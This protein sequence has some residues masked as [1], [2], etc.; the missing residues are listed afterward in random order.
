MIER[1]EFNDVETYPEVSNF[2]SLKCERRYSRRHDMY[3][4]I[5]TKVATRS[6]PSYTIDERA[7]SDC[8]NYSFTF[9]ECLPIDSMI[10]SHLLQVLPVLLSTL[11]AATAFQSRTTLSKRMLPSKQTVLFSGLGGASEESNSGGL[12]SMKSLQSQLASAFTALDERDQYDAVLTGLCAK[13]LDT[14]KAAS[15]DPTAQALR[16]PMQLVEEM[17]TRRIKASPRSLMAF[18]DVS[19]HF[20]GTFCMIC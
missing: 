1:V 18:I 16:D 8:I 13:I 4:A 15:V 5:Q 3:S 20:D 12:M 2:K 14:P 11:E 19:M 17:N 10:F 6:A 9:R 7:E